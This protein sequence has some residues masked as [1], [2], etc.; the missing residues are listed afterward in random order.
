MW[1]ASRNAR[2]S[3]RSVS[4]KGRTTIPERGMHAAQAARAGAPKQPQEK[5][6]RLIVLGMRNG[7]SR[8]V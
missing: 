5:R 2:T 6:L 8:G 4:M 1:P 7:N 3:E